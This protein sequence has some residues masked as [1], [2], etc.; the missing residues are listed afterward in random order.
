MRK[1][2]RQAKIADLIQS[3]VVRN[4]KDL[5]ELLAKSG[6]EISQVTL[7]RDLKEMSVEKIRDLQG[8]LFYSLPVKAVEETG[9][10]DCFRQ[11]F[12]TSC[13]H[14][15]VFSHFV[16]IRLLG[17]YAQSLK[18]YFRNLKL[19]GVV[20]IQ[21]DTDEIW[22]ICFDEKSSEELGKFLQAV[23]H[24]TENIG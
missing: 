5:L 21:A 2:V 15:T 22:F 9:K 7:S 11:L 8:E 10:Q 12:K 19:R 20:G 4:Q 1:Y 18:Q 14:V 23:L 16:C 17:P 3:N 24:E 13:E 6:V